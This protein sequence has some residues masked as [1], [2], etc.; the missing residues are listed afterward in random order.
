MKKQDN[1][2]FLCKMKPQSLA[3]INK[4]TNSFRFRVRHVTTLEDYIVLY[5]IQRQD[6]K[7]TWFF[8]VNIDQGRG[9]NL[10]GCFPYFVL[11]SDKEEI[12]KLNSLKEREVIKW[13]GKR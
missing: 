7:P 1:L 10:N 13:V 4:K 2:F 12:D 5:C 9:V 11:L 8:A 6:G 3:A